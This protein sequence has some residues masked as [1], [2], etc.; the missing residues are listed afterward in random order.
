M[1]SPDQHLFFWFSVVYSTVGEIKMTKFLIIFAICTLI[2]GVVVR[3]D[4]RSKADIVQQCAK[5]Y[6]I[7]KDALKY[8]DVK[9]FKDIV[10]SENLKVNLLIIW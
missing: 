2:G 3:A 8:L 9:K 7:T 10:P 4:K 5:E 1:A 6:S